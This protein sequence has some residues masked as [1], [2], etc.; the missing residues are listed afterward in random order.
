MLPQG[1]GEVSNFHVATKQ[2]IVC[3]ST[4]HGRIGPKLHMF[5]DRP[6]LNTCTCTFSVIITAPPNGNRK[7]HALYF[8][9]QHQDIF[10]LPAENKEVIKADGCSGSKKIEFRK[11]QELQNVSSKTGTLNHNSEEI[12]SITA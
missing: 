8:D 12:I 1:R 3:Y 7:C 10:F 11:S 9:I 5:D 4:V 2:E 6:G